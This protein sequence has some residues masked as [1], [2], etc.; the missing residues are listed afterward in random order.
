VGTGIMGEIIFFF[1]DRW[2]RT[3]R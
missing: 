1:V 3:D 2:Y